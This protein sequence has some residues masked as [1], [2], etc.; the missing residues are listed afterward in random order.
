MR[1]ERVE[2]PGRIIRCETCHAAR[3]ARGDI[4]T[5]TAAHSPS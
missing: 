5:A 2:P 4:T 1:V 3:S